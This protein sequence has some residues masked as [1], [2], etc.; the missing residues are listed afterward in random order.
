[1]KIKFQNKFLKNPT[2]DNELLNKKNVDESIGEGSI[3][4]FNQNLQ[5]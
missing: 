1:M 5:N 3:L 2:S 4:R